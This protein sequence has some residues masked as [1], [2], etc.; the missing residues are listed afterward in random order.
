MESDQII[1]LGLFDNEADFV[2]ECKRYNTLGDLYVGVNPRSLQLLDHFGGLK[3]RMRSVF[4]DV[5]VDLKI[6]HITGIAVP[7]EIPLSDQAE[8][9]TSEASILHDGDTFFAFGSSLDSGCRRLLR[10]W[11][12]DP[13]QSWHYDLH[14]Y[15][16]VT[17][18]ALSDA[19]FFSRRASFKRYRPYQ[20]TEITE[21]ILAMSDAS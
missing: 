1:G 16:R 18:T 20:L 12:T 4:T 21:A 9:L 14:Q 19:G 11:V 2:A 13:D 5:T 6:E 17:G 3:N 8:A 15:I 10:T 7:D